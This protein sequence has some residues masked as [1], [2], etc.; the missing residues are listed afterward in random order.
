MMKAYAERSGQVLDEGAVAAAMTWSDPDRDVSHARELALAMA[1]ADPPL[2]CVWT[3]ERLDAGNLDVDH[4]L[5]WSAWPWGYLWN[6]MPAH[7][8]VNQ[9]LKRE[10]LPSAPTLRD[11]GPAIRGWWS[12]AS[13]EPNGALRSR[14][15]EE[16][17]ASL[18]TLEAD[19][20][21]A[22][23]DRVFATL[24]LQR[25][26]LRQDQRVSEWRG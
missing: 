1:D 9:R 15:A 17:A 10:K 25:L 13:V 20:I 3:G 6:L 7:R 4:F 11:A 2:R 24:E 22:T 16:A 21:S 5:P 14:F 8:K 18:P 19:P 26:R 23:P 12:S